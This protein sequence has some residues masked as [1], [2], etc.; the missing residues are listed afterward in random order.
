MNADERLFEDK[1]YPKADTD[2]NLNRYRD[3]DATRSVERK[4][5]SELVS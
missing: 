1:L 2:H 3:G 4:D 5:V